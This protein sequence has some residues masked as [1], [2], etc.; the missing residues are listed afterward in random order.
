MSSKETS[1]RFRPCSVLANESPQVE[2]ESVERSAV[3][4]ETF[5]PDKGAALG[6]KMIDAGVDVVAMQF[7][8]AGRSKPGTRA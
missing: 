4:G 7:D 2:N 6:D 1:P 8:D 5:H 3:E